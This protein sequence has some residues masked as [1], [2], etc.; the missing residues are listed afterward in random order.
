VNSRGVSQLADATQRTILF[1]IADTGAGHR[2]AANAISNAI[3]IIAEQEKAEWQASQERELAQSEVGDEHRNN[4]SGY[5]TAT[6]IEES[7]PPNYRIEI[8]DVFQEYSRF[9]LREAMK[10]YG[11]AI[12]YNPKLYGELF[13]Q[14]NKEVTIKT[15]NVLGTPLIFNGLLRLFTTIQPDIVVSVHPL[16]N[17]VTIRAL[18]QLGLRIPFITV[19]TDLV[20][21]HY[22]WFAPGADAYIVPTEQARQLYLKRGLEPRRVS[23]LGMPID[24]KFTRAVAAKAEL[25][26]RFELQ[27]GV[28]V[29]L[30]VGGGDGAGGLQAAVRAISQA[31]LPVQLLVVT[32]RN[33]RLYAQLQR[34]RE[35]LH[36]PTKIFGFVQNMPEL[37]H[38][39]DVIITKAGPGT[40]CEALA[41]H[42]PI[43][44]SGYVPGQEEGN[45]DY[46][47]KN[48]MGVLALNA[49]TLI[50]AL[51]RYVKPGSLETKRALENGQKLSKP[52][53]SFDIARMLLSYLP[54]NGVA[55]VWQSHDSRLVKSRMSGRLRSS[56]RIRRPRGRLSRAA[57]PRT[58]RRTV[59]RIRRKTH[60]ISGESRRTRE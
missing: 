33:K 51:R 31:R 19:V 22:S 30:L 12:R 59:L 48:E 8:V 32:G 21:I 55:S 41:C 44:L 40:I 29:V 9:P 53:A 13:H 56:I 28:P 26:K 17:F 15:A 35:R 46:V 36:V 20:S 11:P 16:V 25:Q 43:I 18:R 6:A 58:T 42:L 4:A 39:A 47:V 1:L 49:S 2:S 34:T 24:P 54:A 10:L 5:A 37:M 52:F 38:A 3:R 50:D 7:A 14:S 23:M 45:V 27:A 60:D 57:V